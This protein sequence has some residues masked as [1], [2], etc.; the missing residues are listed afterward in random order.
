MILLY[1]VLKLKISITFMRYVSQYK[2][3]TCMIRNIS[4]SVFYEIVI[5]YEDII[6]TDK[7]LWINIKN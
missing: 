5:A 6:F 3:D 2:L 7:S 4:F 1:L